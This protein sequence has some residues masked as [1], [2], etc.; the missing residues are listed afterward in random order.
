MKVRRTQVFK[1]S[2]AHYPS[3]RFMTY[4]QVHAMRRA[5]QTI[6]DAQKAIEKDEQVAD[7]FAKFWTMV[8]N[9][10]KTAS[11][12]KITPCI[13]PWFLIAALFTPTFPEYEGEDFTDSGVGCT[14]DCLEPAVEVEI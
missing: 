3:A 12:F 2:T 11:W 13:L 4:E 6:W 5:D 9:E 14:D 7:A 1:Q 8:S 10:M